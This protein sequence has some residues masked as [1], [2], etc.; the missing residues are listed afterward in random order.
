MKILNLESSQILSFRCRS[1][2]KSGKHQVTKTGNLRWHN[3]EIKSDTDGNFPGDIV[4][5]FVLE[6]VKSTRPVSGDILGKS[7]S[8]IVGN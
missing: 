3:W 1:G 5:K 4:G 2:I 7:K 8:D 6:G